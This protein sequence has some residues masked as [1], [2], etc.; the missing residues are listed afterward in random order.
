MSRWSTRALALLLGVCL[1]AVLFVVVVVVPDPQLFLRPFPR[2]MAW[3]LGTPTVTELGT[4][5]ARDCLE[6]SETLHVV[7][8]PR[9][10][11]EPIREKEVENDRRFVRAEFSGHWAETRVV[12]FKLHERTVEIEAYDNT[13]TGLY[14]G[15]VDSV[16]SAV[17]LHASALCF[18]LVVEG[19]DSSSR[20]ERWRGQIQLE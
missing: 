8:G 15:S 12:Q 16:R 4:S 2:L 9:D 3:Y 19:I 6:L 17:H 10:L 7:S 14:V 1:A 5:P 20:E 13:C 11:F 18:D